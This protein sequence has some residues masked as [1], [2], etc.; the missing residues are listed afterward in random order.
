MS[1]RSERSADG[2]VAAPRF[3]SSP[4]YTL[5]NGHTL[6]IATADGGNGPTTSVIWCH[7]KWRPPS[8][9]RGHHA[10]HDPGIR[11]PGLSIRPGHGLFD[12]DIKDI[13]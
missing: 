8:S 10:Q 2:P 13:R 3:L 11:R 6:D 1:S 7:P 5:A 12:K 9:N 4:A